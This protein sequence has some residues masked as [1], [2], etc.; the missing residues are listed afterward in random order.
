MKCF[1]LS[2]EDAQDKDDCRLRI[3]VA[4][5]WT[6][7][8]L[9]NACLTA[10][11]CEWHFSKIYLKYIPTISCWPPNFCLYKRLP[12]VCWEIC[13][14]VSSVVFLAKSMIFGEWGYLSLRLATSVEGLYLSDGSR[15]KWLTL[16]KVQKTAGG[17]QLYLVDAYCHVLWLKA[18]FFVREQRCLS[19]LTQI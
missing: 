14:W 10:C 5:G 1:S 15:V 3:K 18:Y 13:L 7:V 19:L 12:T 8:D 17:G 4:Q 6:Q 16:G 9:K 2:C 11:E